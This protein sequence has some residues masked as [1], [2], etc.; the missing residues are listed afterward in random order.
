MTNSVRIN[1]ILNVFDTQFTSP[2]SVAVYHSALSRVN[3]KITDGTA[4]TRVRIP[5]RANQISY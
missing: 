1:T 5:V 2:D 4:G 3:H